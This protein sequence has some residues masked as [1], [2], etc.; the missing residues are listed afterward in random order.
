MLP[1]V[2]NSINS[3]IYWADSYGYQVAFVAYGEDSI[4]D[5]AKY[6]EINSNNTLET[7]L[8]CLL[9]ECGHLL[10]HNNGSTFNFFKISKNFSEK[11]NTHKVFRVI[12]EI[13]AWKRGRGL[14]KRLCINIDEDA[15]NRR[16]CSAIKKYM[17]WALE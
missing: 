5:S 12:E 10:I 8:Y 6:I 15:W 4:C 7:Q 14:A 1:N 3:L 16:I 9:H 11:S 13:E 2:R 17:A